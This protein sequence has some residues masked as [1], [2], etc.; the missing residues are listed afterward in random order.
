MISRV[1]VIIVSAGKGIRLGVSD[2]ATLNL[3]GKPLFL[4]SLRTF[5][6]TKQVKQIILVMRKKHFSLATKKIKDKRIVLVEGGPKRKDSVQKGL[7]ALDKGI[8]YVLI[9]D[10][11]RPFVSKKTILNM[12]KALKKH[13][14]VICGIRPTDTVKFTKG[15]SVTK[16]VNR[17]GLFLTQT[18]QGFKKD[19]IASAYKRLGR[20]N[21]TDDAQLIEHL[22]KPIKV[23]E[24]DCLNFKITY[25]SDVKLAKRIYNVKI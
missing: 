9:H 16:T 10:G 8:N 19:L 25:P 1:G 2:K 21:F 15:D 17:D 14:A 13:P 3:C 22:G 23:I 5:R 20:K 12:L 18:P 7:A 11:A 4:H 6:S 24:S